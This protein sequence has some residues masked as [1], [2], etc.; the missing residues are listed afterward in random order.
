MIAKLK[1]NIAEQKATNG[2]RERFRDNKERRKRVA[3][4]IGVSIDANKDGEISKE[5]LIDYVLH[6][7]DRIALLEKRGLP[8]R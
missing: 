1:P 3:S 7:E 5:E 4:R 6:L 8:N 2:S